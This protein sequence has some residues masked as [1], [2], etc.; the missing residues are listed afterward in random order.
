MLSK[1]SSN[2]ITGSK[3][4][5]WQQTYTIVSSSS[6]DWL[7]DLSFS[8]E[9][10]ILS[11]TN[12]NTVSLS[13]LSTIASH[14]TTHTISGSDPLSPADIGAISSPDSS[15]LYIVSLPQSAYDALPSPDATTLYL[16]TD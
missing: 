6:A 4:D 10:N 3:L 16:I 12:G 15:V 14:A 8:E 1:V 2:M 13:G 11:I 9:S 5:Q 7:Q